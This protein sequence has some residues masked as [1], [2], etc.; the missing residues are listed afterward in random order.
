MHY[1]NAS[2]GMPNLGMP[3]QPPM[4][5]GSNQFMGGMPQR[6]D[7]MRSSMQMPPGSWGM[8]MSSS[9]AEESA[10][11]EARNNVRGGYKCSKCGLPKKGHVC[12][13]QPRLR[14]RDEDET[15]EKNTMAVQVEIDPAMTVRE[16]DLEIQGTPE[17]YPHLLNAFNENNNNSA[18]PPPPPQAFN[19]QHSH[20][21]MHEGGY[22]HSNSSKSQHHNQP[23]H[24]RPGYYHHNDPSPPPPP[25]QDERYDRNH[26]S[27]HQQSG[28]E[29]L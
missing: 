16:L 29:G 8:P 1:P 12:A 28:D 25:L 18:S 24:G 22:H 23:D 9:T 17:S 13:Y 21:N 20:Q 10:A 4:M 6:Y 19:S 26:R 2:H 5:M 3:N 27:N 7:G 15:I 14:R 11:E